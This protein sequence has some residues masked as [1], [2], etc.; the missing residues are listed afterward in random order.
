MSTST[1]PISRLGRLATP[2]IGLNL[3]AVLTLA[4]DTAMVGRLPEAE[5]A[6]AALGFSGNIAFLLLVAMIGV[7]VGTVAM[8]SRAYGAGDHERVN[9]VVAQSVLVTIVLGA[10]VACLGNLFA[11]PLLGLLGASDA[12]KGPALAYLRPVMAGQVFPFLVI[13]YAAVLR[14]I[15]NTRLPFFV[16]LGQNAINIALNYGL[17]LG[18]FGMP[19][20][21]ISGAAVATV[22]SQ[23]LGAGTLM[24]IAR[25]GALRPLVVPVRPPRLDP[26]IARELGRVGAPAALDLVILNAAFLSIVGMLGRITDDAVAAHGIGLRIQSL[27]FV[28]ALGVSQATAA[29][30]GQ[31]LGA[32]EPDAARRTLRAS[33]VLSGAISTALAAVILLFSRVIVGIFDVAPGTEL[34]RLALTWIAV[35]GFGMPITGVF[36]AY[37][38]LLM[39][40]GKTGTNLRINAFVTFVFQ[41]PASAV[42]G[43]ALG[44]GAAGV[45]VGFPLSFA[46]KLALSHLAYRRGAWAVTGASP[47]GDAAGPSEGGPPGR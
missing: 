39:G 15:G 43:F 4:V 17:I 27:A 1:T 10:V 7:T 8:V 14:G 23:A 24:W 3:L 44:L 31:A 13:L 5:V 42:L 36:M 25:S 28:P 11:R 21:G 9:H 47:V 35:L 37:V 38:G 16:A 41:I 45:W 2:V 6:L 30:V 46:A 32:G 34:E 12:V 19:Q 40:A 20:L 26:P 33:I 29:L 22:I 18:G